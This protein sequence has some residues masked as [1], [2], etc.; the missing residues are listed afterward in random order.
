LTAIIG[1]RPAPSH[2]RSVDLRVD[3]ETGVTLARIIASAIPIPGH[4]N[5]V[6]NAAVDLAQ[7]GHDVTMLMAPALEQAVTAAGLKYTPLEGLPELETPEFGAAMSQAAPG[8]GQLNVALRH[9]FVEPMAAQYA[10]L[11]EQLELI[12]DEPSVLLSDNYFLGGWPAALG[13]AGRR[14]TA[15]IA[16]GINMLTTLS[17]YAPPFGARLTLAGTSA[18]QEQIA[19]ANADFRAAFQPLQDAFE[20]AVKALGAT[21]PVPFFFDALATVPDRLLQLCGWWR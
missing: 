17:A 18:D 16:L 12:D 14:P 8:P 11:Q 21:A 13:A 19:Q 10:A 9:F 20:R 1:R 3:S 7:R 4:F 5:P 6:R 2:S 15:T